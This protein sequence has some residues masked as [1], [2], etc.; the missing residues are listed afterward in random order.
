MAGNET[1]EDLISPT[2][3]RYLQVIDTLSNMWPLHWEQSWI[4]FCEKTFLPHYPTQ[5]TEKYLLSNAWLGFSM[6]QVYAGGRPVA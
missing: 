2:S 6:Q 5:V 1:P 4:N 3:A